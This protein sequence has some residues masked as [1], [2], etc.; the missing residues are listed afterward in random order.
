MSTPTLTERNGDII[1]L[2]VC[3]RSHAE[4]ACTACDDERGI[5]DQ[6]VPDTNGDPEP[7]TGS[8]DAAREREAPA[9]IPPPAPAHKFA[10]KLSQKKKYSLLFIFSMAL[11][12]DQWCLAAFFIFTNPIVQD[13]RVEHSQQSWIITSYAV[14]FA[15]SLLFWGR[16]SD[17]YSARAVFSYGFLALGVLS[18]IISFLPEQYSFFIFRALSGLAGGTLVPSAFRLIV[19]V[20]EPHELKKAFTLYGVAG[21]L[22]ATSGVIVAGPLAATSGVIVAGLM[23]LIKKHN[24]LAGWRWEQGGSTDVI[25]DKW[26]RLDLVGSFTMLATI[27]LLVLSFTLGATS[28]FPSAGFLA[29]FFISL[30]LIGLFFYWESCLPVTHALLPPQV[31]KYRDFAL[32]IA[33]GLFPQGWW[34]IQMLPVVQV[35]REVRGES[36]LMAAVRMLP[37]PIGATVA[38]IIATNFPRTASKP[39]WAVAVNITIGIAML[40]LFAE[41]R[42]QV[43]RD[44][45]KYL[46][47]GWLVASAAMMFLYNANNVGVMTSVPP[48]MAG[49]AGALLQVAVQTGNAIALGVQAGLL[50]V[51]PGGYHDWRNIQAS[52]YFQ[53]GWGAIW[54]IGFLVL[55]RPK[56]KALEQGDEKAEGKRQTAAV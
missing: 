13:L 40:V 6:H 2:P 45:W 55:Y 24:Q 25:K 12:I 56:K 15:A 21:P 17:L 50:T 46:L 1:N 19:M 48:E 22:A 29:P 38:T 27:I 10:V 41:S 35:F 34:S 52:S 26:K 30:V 8:M 5:K 28:G 36:Y 47:P 20:F 11:F 14:T 42:T 54:M 3:L 33:F 18:I 51:H 16:M 43:G 31:W 53:M 23:E 9:P 44:Y 7:C 39:R 37:M 49:V 32:W 4:T